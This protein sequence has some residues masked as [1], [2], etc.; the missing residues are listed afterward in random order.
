MLYRTLMLSLGRIP[1]L[2]PG[3]HASIYAYLEELAAWVRLS[4][5]PNA[6]EDQLKVHQA[7]TAKGFKDVKALS[8]GLQ[9]W[10]ALL[11]VSILRPWLVTVGFLLPPA[12]ILW[13]LLI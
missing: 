11:G 7:N 8:R 9:A 6:S 3:D 13:H 1:G 2:R 12:A 10:V 5:D 4:T